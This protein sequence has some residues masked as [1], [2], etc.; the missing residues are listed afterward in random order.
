MMLDR[1]HAPVWVCV[2]LILLLALLPTGFE[3][4]EVFQESDIRP[5]LVLSTDES[6]VIDTGLIRSGEQ[7]CR[8]EILSGP[9][10]G[11]HA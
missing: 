3:G 8:L 1:Y 6:T 11:Y 2:L 10:R 4:Q 7:R 9:F 5:A